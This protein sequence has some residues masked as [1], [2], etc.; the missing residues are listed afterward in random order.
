ML[1]ERVLMTPKGYRKLEEELIRLRT[2]KRAEVAAQIREAVDEGGEL[3]ENAAYDL[4]KAE[5]SFL[6]GRILG[7][8]ET[9]ARADIVDP[10]GSSTVV[11]IGSTVEVQMDAGLPEQFTIVGKREADAKQRMIS[12]ESPLGGAVLERRAGETFEVVTPD[13]RMSVTLLRIL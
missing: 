2:V 8:E 10:L 9:L 3:E 7:I 12:Y 4:A 5:Q 13:G 11:G 1:R 6:E